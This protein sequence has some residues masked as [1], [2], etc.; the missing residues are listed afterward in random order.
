MWSVSAIR[1]SPG[2]AAYTPFRSPH[3]SSAAEPSPLSE[4]S[5]QQLGTPSSPSSRQTE[6]AFRVPSAAGKR[7][8]RHNT[9]P[10]RTQA[11]LNNTSNRQWTRLG[12]FIDIQTILVLS[13]VERNPGPLPTKSPQPVLLS[14]ININS[15][16]AGNKLDE[17]EQ[18]VDVNDV[19]ILALTETKLSD[20]VATSQYKLEHFHAPITR[21]RDRH[22]GGVALYIHKSLSFRRLHH[23]ELGDTGTSRTDWLRHHSSSSVLHHWTRPGHG[24]HSP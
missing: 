3:Y 24:W 6:S 20:N 2:T 1:A 4:T 5:V 14:H 9:H 12:T 10:T 15:I 7:T 17:L 16:T 18:F 11:T 19:S 23:L 22:G 13:G 21:H 8:H